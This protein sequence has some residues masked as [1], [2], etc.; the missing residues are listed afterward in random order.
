MTLPKHLE[1]LFTTDEGDIAPE[2]LSRLQVPP[3]G[4]ERLPAP[5]PDRL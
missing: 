2:N 1:Q 5:A 4:P 3:G